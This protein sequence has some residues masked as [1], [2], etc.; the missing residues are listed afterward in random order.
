MDAAI[1]FAIGY[2]FVAKKT[3]TKNADTQVWDDACGNQK[4]DIIFG[5]LRIRYI[6]L[7]PLVFKK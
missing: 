6:N 2:C 7:N 1:S 5:G 4:L 3:K